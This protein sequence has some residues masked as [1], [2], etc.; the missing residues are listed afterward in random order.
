MKKNVI[1]LTEGDLKRIISESVRKV[2]REANLPEEGGL[3][4]ACHKATL[5]GEDD[6][7]MGKIADAIY[8]KFSHNEMDVQEVIDAVLDYGVDYNDD[9]E[10]VIPQSC[11]KLGTSVDGRY[12][13]TYESLTGTYDVW[14]KQ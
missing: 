2:L 1:R 3:E 7:E 4:Y 14:E 10:S 13:L 9:E 12:I 5:S 11:H 6:P 8:D